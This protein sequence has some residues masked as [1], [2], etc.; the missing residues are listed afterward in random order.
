MRQFKINFLTLLVISTFSQAEAGEPYW[1]LGLG[2][3]WK[4][5]STYDPDMLQ[6]AS[7][8]YGYGFNEHWAV[9][10]DY[11][12]SFGGGEFSRRDS[13]LTSGKETGEYSTWMSSLGINY[14][15][16]IND[17]FYLK[18]QAAYNYVEEERTSSEAG[19]GDYSV[20][21]SG[22]IGLGGGVLLGDVVGSSLTLELDYTYYFNDLMGLMIGVNATF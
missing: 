1:M 9:E 2:A 14:R 7:I 10:L 16:L 20:E 3:L 12:Q 22:L 4:S 15:H 19:M 21:H 13:T 8:T 5:D 11:L 17:T 18:G 6:A